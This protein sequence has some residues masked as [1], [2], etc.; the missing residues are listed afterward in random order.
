M[1]AYNFLKE[2]NVHLVYGGSRYLIKTT[3]DVSFSQ[4]FAEDAYEVKT[5]HDQTKMFQGTSITKAN[6]ADFSF[7]VHLT[8]EKD[9][10]IVKSLLTDYDTTEGQTRIK[11]FDL[12]IVTGESTFKLNECVL[13]NGDFNLSKGSA[14]TLA[15][16]GQGQKLERVGDASYSL[17]GSLVSASSTRTPTLSLIDVEVGGSDVTNIISATLSVQNEISWT[18]YETLQSS[19]SVTSASNA[20][21]PSGFTLGRRV[22]SG[23]IVQYIT[24]NNS[25]TVQTFDTDTTVRVKTVVDGSTF[26]DANLANCMFTKRANVADVFT[27]TFD[28]RLV[29]NPANLSTVI[30]Y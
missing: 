22:V 24:S 4:T 11:T 2:S 23:N 6:P 29:G 28:Y 3:P 18:P 20:M 16:A 27:Q 8:K 7:T 21:Y 30:T 19:L 25:S 9:E 17:P 10:T 26:L 5:L 15:V 12:Y 13:I 1:V 14:S